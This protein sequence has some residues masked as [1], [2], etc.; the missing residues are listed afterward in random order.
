MIS[1]S[2][3]ESSNKTY[4]FFLAMF[5]LKQFF[6]TIDVGGL[7]TRSLLIDSNMVSSCN[8]NRIFICPKTST[9]QPLR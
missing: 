2:Q 5:N 1:G 8:F 4:T 9:L 7:E 3:T 6:N